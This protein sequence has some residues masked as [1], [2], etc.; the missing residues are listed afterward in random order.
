MASKTG[1]IFL[2]LSAQKHRRPINI[3]SKT[4]I[5]F[6][7]PGCLVDIQRCKNLLLIFWI[8]ANI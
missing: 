3:V 4:P 2:R 1:E 7:Y 8:I 5:C 6:I